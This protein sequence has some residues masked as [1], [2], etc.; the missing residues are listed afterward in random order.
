MDN[1]ASPIIFMH[2]VLKG[3]ANFGE[4]RGIL[5]EEMESRLRI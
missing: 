5:P 1:F 2:N 3:V 4:I